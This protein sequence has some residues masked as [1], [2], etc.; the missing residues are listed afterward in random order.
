VTLDPS[1]L[2]P[3]LP[4]EDR[5]ERLLAQMTLEEK[6]GQL[7]QYVGLRPDGEQASAGNP[8]EVAG[9]ALAVE[10][11]AALVR[12]GLAG[13][14]LKVAGWR[15]ADRL[16]ELAETS[17]LR[18]PLL[19][20]T[21]AIHGHAMDLPAATVFPTPIGIAASFDPDL[22]ERIA[23]ATAR[24][25]RATGYHWTFSPNVD[26]TRDPRW[27]R[28]G[29]TFGED[30]LLCGALGAA[31][32]RGYQGEDL[33][34]EAAV[35]ACAKHLVGGG[36]PENGL[37]GAP[38]D[39]SSRTLEEVLLPPFRRAVEAGVETV[40]PAHNEVNG[41][42]CHGDR[43]LLSERLRGAWGFRG[44]VVSDWLDVEKLHSVH[45]VAESRRDATRLAVEAGI[46]VNM[47]GRAFLDDLLALVRSGAI[48]E[49][50]VDASVRRVLLAKLRLG[51][52]ERR[53]VDEARAREV[54]L[55]PA[56]RELAL[57]A[58]RRSLVL[59]ENRGGLLPLRAP[60]TLLVSG[61]CADDQSLL[62]DWSRRQPRENVA[63]VLDGLRALAPRGT[64][65]THAACG[66]IAALDARAIARV[67][68][69]ARTADACVLVVGESSLREDPARTSGENLDRAS[70]ELPGRQAELVRAVLA[71]GTPT[72]IVLVNGA[73]I[74]GE[75][76]ADAPAI[77]EAWEPGM[78]GGTAVAEAIYGLRSPSGRMPITVPRSA[79]HVRTH[80]AMR[81]SATH[82]GRLAAGPVEPWFRFGH[83]LSYTS[84]AYRELRVKESVTVGEPVSVLLEVENA[85]AMAGEE[86]VLVYLED[87]FASVTR[88]ARELVAFRR[89]ALAPGERQAVELLLW[90]EALSLLDE[91]LQ[92]TIE[93]G[94]FRVIVGE[95]L[96]SATFRVV[97]RTR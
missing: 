91:D 70:L 85:G 43:R 80:G 6:L 60:R 50:R 30:P 89:V 48:P 77:L 94:E 33:S 46:D 49:A 9:Y 51:L 95:E 16:Q 83:G 44:L 17:R 72:V 47:H 2:D 78:A 26:V 57:E 7:C 42:P 39:V 54:V 38:A 53:R 88:P 68:R 81:P 87:R 24:E 82:R 22:A 63:T 52:F 1:Y 97:P 93:P 90:P 3:S 84:F 34:G 58:A 5:A 27:G 19:V 61:P 20:A 11:Q 75:W 21:D 92:P 59:L 31:M 40:M 13:S 76:L 35:L 14:F 69:R 37:N 12:A 15:E 4:P 56:H 66:T 18:I 64:R 86:V 65:V 96:L 62:G 73:P 29:E 32:V 74:A 41:I 45:R 71:T 25:L 55:A 67:V 8:D 23:A 36:V 28:T 79:G 10:E